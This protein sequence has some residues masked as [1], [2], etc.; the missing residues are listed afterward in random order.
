MESLKIS[1]LRI[2]LFET[3]LNDVTS[4]NQF[5]LIVYDFF[6]SSCSNGNGV[7]ICICVANQL[8]KRAVVVSFRDLSHSNYL[9]FVAVKRFPRCLLFTGLSRVG[10]R[11]SLV[12]FQKEYNLFQLKYCSWYTNIIICSKN[13][14]SSSTIEYETV[15]N[16]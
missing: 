12:S 8:K 5:K 10:F 3:W 16:S 15:L 6:C 14:Q 2:A 4:F 11:F 1:F 7:S 9:Y 13:I